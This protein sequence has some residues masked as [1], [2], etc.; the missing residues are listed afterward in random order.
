M[1]ASRVTKACA[2]GMIA[3]QNVGAVW[4]ANGSGVRQ[5]R[6]A[7]C[8]RQHS[9]I[10]NSGQWEVGLYR[11]TGPALGWCGEEA[12]SPAGRTGSDSWWEAPGGATRANVKLW[13]ECNG[14]SSVCPRAAVFK[15]V[16]EAHV[17]PSQPPMRSNAAC[18]AVNRK[19]LEAA[20]KPMSA[21]RSWFRRTN[22]NTYHM[23]KWVAR[24]V[25]VTRF[26]TFAGNERCSA[27][28]AR[29]LRRQQV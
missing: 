1:A 17:R 29:V 22:T 24:Q 28:C 27:P 9:K 23:A 21:A 7:K 14:R 13:R 3:C 10:K 12:R 5:Q 26:T 2:Y 18:E 20:Q 16:P 25:K 11:R 8:V 19:N 6:N 15:I 4:N